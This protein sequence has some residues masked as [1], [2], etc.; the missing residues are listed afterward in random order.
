MSAMAR[1]RAAT[2]RKPTHTISS[3]MGG[4]FDV[5]VE[6]ETDGW[7]RVKI[8]YPGGDFHGREVTVPVAQLVP[9]TNVAA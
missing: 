1:K 6:Q 9:R 3:G 5:H 4:R 2:T 8:H 7:A